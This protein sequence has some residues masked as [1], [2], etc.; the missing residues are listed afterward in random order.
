MLAA[1][2]ALASAV[3][4]M[5][6]VVRRLL[7]PLERLHQVVQQSA[8]DFSAHRALPITRKDEIG[9][10]AMTF[11]LLM[12]QLSEREAALH[13]AKDSAHESQKRI[14][15]I[16]NHLP[17]LVSYV[18]VDERYV[19]VNEAYERRFGLSTAQMVGLSI[20]ELWG[21]PAY[22]DVKPY[23]DRAF[24]G[25]SVTF[26]REFRDGSGCLEVSYQPAWNDAEDT[27]VGLHICEARSQ[28]TA[29]FTDSQAVVI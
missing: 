24:A 26:D 17:D 8:T 23:L 20:Q 27:V 14:Q 11:S 10:L 28:R 6:L 13:E 5:W 3:L 21:A 4:L 15:A 7:V 19:Y 22:A 18:G 12:H 1:G 9:D 16:A 25:A 29:S 2:I